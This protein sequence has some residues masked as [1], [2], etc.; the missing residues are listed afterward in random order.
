MRCNL[1]QA[2]EIMKSMSSNIVQMKRHVK[3][4]DTT[5]IDEKSMSSDIAQMKLRVQ[6]SQVTIMHEATDKKKKERKRGYRWWVMRRTCLT[7][8]PREQGGS[9]SSSSTSCALFVPRIGPAS[10]RG[11]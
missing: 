1:C 5:E 10:P 4:H 8:K 6:Q 11:A 3:R 2:T 9:L 7:P